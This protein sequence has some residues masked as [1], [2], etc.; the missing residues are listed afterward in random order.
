MMKTKRVATL[1]NF[2]AISPI[3]E[4]HKPTRKVC[5]SVDS[6]FPLKGISI[7]HSYFP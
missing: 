5:N 4:F 7:A 3:C 2:I 1:Q 6:V